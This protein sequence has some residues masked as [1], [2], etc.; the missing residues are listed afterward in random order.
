MGRRKGMRQVGVGWELNRRLSLLLVEL[1]LLVLLE[2]IVPQQRVGHLGVQQV[3]ERG[4]GGFLAWGECPDA[5]PWVCPS[6]AAPVA[7]LGHASPLV[8]GRACGSAPLSKS[9]RSA[10]CLAPALLP[11][12]YACKCVYV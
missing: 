10:D 1:L 9:M 8:P 2:G 11:A 7:E 12:A 5:L 4:A 3:G 6:K